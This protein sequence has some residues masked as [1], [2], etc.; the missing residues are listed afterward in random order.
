V[1]GANLR[2]L[3]EEASGVVV[4]FD[5]SKPAR[6]NAQSLSALDEWYHAMADHLPPEEE[7]QQQQEGLPAMILLGN[8]CDSGSSAISPQSLDVVSPPARHHMPRACRT[9]PLAP[10]AA[11]AAAGIG[12]ATT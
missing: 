4:V 7:Q 5:C 6:D 12:G 11:S 3:F 9:S 10:D 8:K 2:R 1:G